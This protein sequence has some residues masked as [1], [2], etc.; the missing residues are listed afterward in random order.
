M[1][2]KTLGKID[3]LKNDLILWLFETTDKRNAIDRTLKEVYIYAQKETAKAI[4][5]DIKDILNEIPTETE[6]ETVKGVFY[7]KTAEEFKND[8]LKKFEERKWLK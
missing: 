3:E 4:K 6:S 5:K 8:V 7:D 2:D 1:K